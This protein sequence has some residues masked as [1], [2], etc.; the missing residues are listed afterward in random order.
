MR[1][2]L[3]TLLVALLTSVAQAQPAKT[4]KVLV[5]GIDGLRPDALEAAKTPFLDELKKAGAW[6]D[7]AQILAARYRKNDTIS[8]PGWSSI[9]TGVWADKHG[10]QDNSFRGSDFSTYPDFFRRLKQ[11]RP[12]ARTA[13]FVSWQPIGD[14]I[15]KGSADES[16]VKSSDNLKAGDYLKQPNPDA[17]FYYFGFADSMGHTK[18][19]HPR[20]PEYI[21]AIELADTCTG[22]VLRG[23]VTRPTFN[24]ENWL[25][26]VTSDH[27]GEGTS[28]SS[29][30]DVPAILN[31]PL[32]IS[33]PAAEL[34]KLHGPAFIVD[35]PVTA[36][37]HLGVK[38][39]RDWKLDGRP[40]G[41]K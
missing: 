35:V 2:V 38:L 41:L 17:V 11:A 31:V 25:V 39:D 1:L 36:L 23:M 33:G 26:L 16:V 28:H 12:T 20:V 14:Q 6:T 15:L 27:G 5:I 7:D 18:G 4:P 32:I 34:G 24:E 22:L 13:A 10:V 8:G 19:F 9:L 3:T 40:V 21:S 37:T 30:L 29:G